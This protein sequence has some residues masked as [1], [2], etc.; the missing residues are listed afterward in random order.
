MSIRLPQSH[1]PIARPEPARLPV[2]RF[3]GWL[4]SVALGAALLLGPVGMALGQSAGGTLEQTKDAKQEVGPAAA[5]RAAIA[6]PPI[7]IRV[8]IAEVG[9]K[10]QGASGLGAGGP[11]QARRAG[12]F[13]LSACNLLFDRLDQ[14]LDAR[15]DQAESARG[16]IHPLDFRR[17]DRNADRGVDRAEFTRGV[18]AILTSRGLEPCSDLASEA[19]RL[20]ALDK[21][22]SRGTRV[23]TR[24]E[25]EAERKR[26]LRE[27]TAP[28]GASAPL[29]RE[30]PIKPAG[31]IKPGGPL[32]PEGPIKAETQIQSEPP[33]GPAVVRRRPPV[34]WLEGDRAK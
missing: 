22:R 15:V 27:R 34:R 14:N 30:G 33:G 4:R 6:S 9:A 31:P 25:L 29:E 26:R 18:C 10:P 16:G 17:G 2:G 28:T 7:L 3:V 32:E 11:A 8:P 13:S 5:R 19:T 12:R 20:A 24:E 23:P 21:I 1:R